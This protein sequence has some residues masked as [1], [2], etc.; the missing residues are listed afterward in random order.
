VSERILFVAP[1]PPSLVRPRSLGILRLLARQHEVRVLA[2][3]DLPKTSAGRSNPSAEGWEVLPLRRSRAL[4]RCAVALARGSSLQVAYAD[5]P[6]LRRA[7]RALVD[8]WSPTVVH[9]NVLR[10]AH[11]ISECSGLRTVVDLD[12][13]R[14]QYY[15]QLA[16]QRSHLKRSLGRYESKA[17]RRLEWR[18]LEEATRVMVSA[19]PTDDRG[20]AANVHVVPTPVWPSIE[21]MPGRDATSPVFLF[22]GRLTYDAN[23]DGITRFVRQCWPDIRQRHV[24]ARLQ[25]VGSSPCRAVRKLGR[26]PGVEVIP[27]VPSVDEYYQSATAAIIPI[28]RGTGVQMKLIQA[29]AAGV[30]VVATPLVAS[31]GGVRDGREVLVADSAQAW[32]RAI[33]RLVESPTLREALS[34]QGKRWYRDNHS[35]ERVMTALEAVY[36]RIPATAQHD[37]IGNGVGVGDREFR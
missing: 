9:F 26:V 34:Q 15:T 11:L 30:P 32:T 12:E 5:A 10:S 28:E 25:V 19:V 23:V 14:S 29:L 21:H 27:D 37:P 3:D 17:M 2:L 31:L 16:A 20:H 13:F 22:A 35:P 36:A 6:S 8:D 7:L 24:A 1:W 18:L 4:G 33:D